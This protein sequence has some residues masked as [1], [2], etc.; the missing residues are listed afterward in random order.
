[1]AAILQ[2]EKGEI[3]IQLDAKVVFVSL[4][5][6][7]DADPEQAAPAIAFLGLRNLLLLY[8]PATP[9]AER[10]TECA[11]LVNAFGAHLSHLAAADVECRARITNAALV[12][13]N[14]NVTG[15]TVMPQTLALLDTLRT[16]QEWDILEVQARRNMTH[17]DAGLARVAKAALVEALMHS[18]EGQKRSE[19]VAL[20]EQLT[21]TP[22]ATVD[23]YML[24]AGAA[25]GAGLPAR[26]VEIVTNALPQW[27]DHGPLLSYGRDLATRTG[28]ASLRSALEAARG[29]H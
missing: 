26:S 13:S 12:T 9:L 21:E 16:E 17:R 10:L 25:E 2:G 14:T 19:A 29:G 8:D 23:D 28:D 7:R 27:P 6:A 4:D 1:M 18:D 24:A 22:E 15:K 11:E 20:A 3:P 5:L